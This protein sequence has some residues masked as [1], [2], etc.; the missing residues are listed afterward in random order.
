MPGTADKRI[1]LPA[2]LG[3]RDG[4][5]LRLARLRALGPRYLAMAALGLLVT[6]GLRSLFSSPPSLS[7]RAPASAD[8]PSQDFA[9]QFARAYLTYDA[10]RPGAR[11]RALAPFVSAVL[12]SGAGFIAA[13]G[14]QRVLWTEVASDQPA[15]IGG[16]VITIAAEVSTQRTPLYL[17]VTVRHPAGQPLSL[18]GYPSFVGA[19]LVDTDAAPVSGEEVSDPAVTE[20]VKRVIR[21]Y[22]ARSAA[23]LEADLTRGAAVTLPTITLALRSVDQITWVGTPGSGAV[24]ITVIAADQRGASYTLTYE[25]G[26]A[27]RERPYVDFIEVIPTSS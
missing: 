14:I 24:L 15:L 21:N 6:L 19:P 11:A 4:Q 26:I 9:L 18:V 20:V 27:Y 25:L 17:A 10:D 5:S 3:S 12:E 16:R 2:A 1:P 13:S 23:N 22:L 8:L 7:P